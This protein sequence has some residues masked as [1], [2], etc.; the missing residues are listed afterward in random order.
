MFKMILSCLL[1]GF[2]L[3]GGTHAFGL[4]DQSKLIEGAKK[5]GKVVYWSSGLTPDLIRRL[6][7]VSRRSM[8]SRISRSY[9]PQPGPRNRSPK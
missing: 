9:F 5:E 1:A 2:L 3:L 7:K 8:D 4:E 6:T